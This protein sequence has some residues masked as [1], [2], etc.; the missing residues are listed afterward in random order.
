MVNVARNLLMQQEGNGYMENMVLE[1]IFTL[2]S[3]N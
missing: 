3:K 1:T 2:M